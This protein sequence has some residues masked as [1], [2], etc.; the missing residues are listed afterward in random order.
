MSRPSRST[1]PLAARLCAGVLACTS[2]AF[3][4]CEDDEGPLLSDA[5]TG[6]PDGSASPDTAP[7]SDA[8]RPDAS[9]GDAT[10][11]DAPPA[12][13]ADLDGV[14]VR[15]NPDGTRDMT[16]GTNGIARI[17]F[18]PGN[19]NTRDSLWGVEVDAMNRL[20]LFGS[21]KGADPR[22]DNDR[23]VVRL[24]PDG[25]IDTTFATAGTH[26]LNIANLG[27]SARH[28]ILEA[29]GKIVASGYT[30]QPTGVGTQDANR[31]VLLRL[32]GAG[33]PDMTFGVNGVINSAPFVPAMPDVT[34]WGM[35]EAYGVA[36]QSTGAYVTTGYGRSA[37][38][39]TVDM[40]SFRFGADGKRDMTWGNM[41]LALFEL[42]MA[43]DRGRNIVGLAEDKILIVGS[44]KPTATTMDALVVKLLATGAPD[45]SF[46][47]DGAKL[48][49]FGRAGDEPF[50]GVAISADKNWVA[51]TG[52]SAE[53]GMTTVDP[54]ATLLLLP[55]GAG[56]GT[57]VSKVVAASE[58]E[59]DGFYA[60]AFDASNKVYGAGYVREG[61]DSLFLVS[62]FNI[63]GTLDTTFAGGNVK[64]NIAVGKGTAEQARDIVIQSDGKI[65]VAGVAEL[66]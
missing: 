7:P 4:A 46:D 38:T 6:N 66:P 35:A 58:T 13:P 50:Y 63:D 16:F 57:E 52:Y 10:A 15:F 29:D 44:A 42:A 23:V 60:A 62:R 24:T 18:G 25:A 48:Y 8:T 39:G 5:S 40:V 55:V 64:V 12:G 21:K 9:G 36:R 53:T 2:L 26:T 51:A 65:V 43:D 59:A 3:T 47:T 11:G 32:D 27:D 22:I 34:P 41:G 54:D 1:H 56:G 14:L 49:D 30:A 19:A 17:D 61:T 33:M 28:G 31:I 45:P 37:A 20:V